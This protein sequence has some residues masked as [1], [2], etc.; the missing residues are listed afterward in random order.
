MNFK[1]GELDIQTTIGQLNFFKWAIENEVIR[2][3]E[4]NYACIWDP[5]LQV[6]LLVAFGVL[7]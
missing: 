6:K 2:Y 3:I 7:G 1:C 5:T 4:N